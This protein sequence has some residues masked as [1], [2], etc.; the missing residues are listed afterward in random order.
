MR[1]M[2]DPNYILESQ[3]FETLRTVCKRLYGD[4]SHM[5]ADQ[6]RD[7]ANLMHLTL[8]KAMTNTDGEDR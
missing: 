3:D 2:R 7:L 4:G 8:S 5:T 1:P 6:R